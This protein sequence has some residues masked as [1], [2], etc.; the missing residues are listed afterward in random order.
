MAKHSKIEEMRGRSIEPRNLFRYYE[1]FG[2]EPPERL[3]LIQ[4]LAAV[5]F[6]LLAAFLF[7]VMFGA[8]TIFLSELQDRLGKN[9]GIAADAAIFVIAFAFGVGLLTFASKE[10]VRRQRRFHPNISLPY[11]P[12]SIFSD[13]SVVCL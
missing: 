11:P 9:L 1:M 13:L 12:L 3:R 4:K 7:L 2:H 10:S 8:G 5:V 6:A